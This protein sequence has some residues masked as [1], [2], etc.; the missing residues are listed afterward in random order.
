MFSPGGM[1]TIIMIIILLLKRRV[2]REE[3]ELT[4]AF[5]KEWT[6]YASKT[7]RFIPKVI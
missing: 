5:G 2:T 1:L 7:K 6:E 3:E 4:K